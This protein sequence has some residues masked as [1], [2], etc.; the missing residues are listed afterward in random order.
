MIFPWCCVHPNQ[1]A[2]HNSW[3]HVSLSCPNS[4]RPRNPAIQFRLVHGSSYEQFKATIILPD[5]NSPERYDHYYPF[6]LQSVFVR[7]AVPLVCTAHECGKALMYLHLFY[8]AFSTFCWNYLL[9]SYRSSCSWNVTEYVCKVMCVKLIIYV[10][11]VS[12]RIG[13]NVCLSVAVHS[14]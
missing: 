13:V 4:L 12:C 1:R 7:Y 11:F 8:S 14:S 5:T 3:R 6:T 9:R 2:V 10:S